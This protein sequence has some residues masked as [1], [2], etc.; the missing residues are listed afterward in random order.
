ME[1]VAELINLMAIA[2]LLSGTA[3]VLL[4]VGTSRKDVSHLMLP[5]YIAELPDR[6]WGMVGIEN[7]RLTSDDCFSLTTRSREGTLYRMLAKPLNNFMVSCVAEHSWSLPEETG[8]AA[9]GDEPLRSVIQTALD[10]EGL[11]PTNSADA[12]EISYYE[13]NLSGNLTLRMHLSDEAYGVWSGI[14]T[15]EKVVDDAARPAAFEALVRLL[16]FYR[17]SPAQQSN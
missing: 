17:G 10:T 5:E 16:K 3:G 9:T 14:A 15:G 4:T 12:L 7:A 13:E 8:I 1:T 6:Y 11:G 2:L